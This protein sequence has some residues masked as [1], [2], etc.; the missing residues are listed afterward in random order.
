[1]KTYMV[2]WGDGYARS[3]RVEYKQE[4]YFSKKMGYEEDTIQDIRQ[5]K[6]GQ[7]HNMSDLSGVQIITCVENDVKTMKCL[8]IN[9]TDE[10]APL[11]EQ[12]ATI[13]RA[14]NDGETFGTG[15][16][17]TEEIL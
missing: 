2:Y 15:W 10:F 6:V 7:S 9:L 3:P 13:E 17:V 14:I 4:S 5:L 8:S 1:M 16:T 11:T 12:L